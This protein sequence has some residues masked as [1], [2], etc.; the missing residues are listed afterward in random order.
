MENFA[1][2]NKEDLIGL[3][4]P[5]FLTTY[6]YQHLTDP[7]VVLSE[8]GITTK[9][10]KHSQLGSLVKLPLPKVFACLQLFIQWVDQ[11]LYDFCNLPLTLKAHLSK[12]DHDFFDCKLRDLWT[13]TPKDLEVEVKQLIDVLKHSE[14]DISKIVNEQTPR[15]SSCLMIVFVI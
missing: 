3:T 15:V 13:G 9:S 8:I 4:L 7:E 6:V 5:E 10:L 14:S 1:S 2:L 11:G 12:A